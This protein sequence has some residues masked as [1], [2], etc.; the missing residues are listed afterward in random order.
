MIEQTVALTATALMHII[1]YILMSERKYS[2]KKTALIY[3]V[4]LAAFIG[5]GFLLSRILFG[6]Y[7]FRA[8]SFS[9]YALFWR[10]FLCL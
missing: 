10:R 7:S 5:L 2:V 1:C 8:I 9:L 6:F 3:S 4:F